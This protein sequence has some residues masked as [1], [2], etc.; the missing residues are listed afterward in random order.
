MSN[1]SKLKLSL[2]G[3]EEIQDRVTEAIKAALAELGVKEF[4]TVVALFM[5]IDPKD[6]N[7]GTDTIWLSSCE[8]DFWTAEILEDIAGAIRK[9]GTN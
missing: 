3:R 5:P 1:K 6:F 4:Q 9:R 7:K 2:V 8:D